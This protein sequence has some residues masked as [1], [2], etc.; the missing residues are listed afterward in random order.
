MTTLKLFEL[1]SG[2][3]YVDTLLRGDTV[4]FSGSKIMSEIRPPKYVTF[5]PS[6]RRDGGGGSLPLLQPLLTLSRC[7]LLDRDF[8]IAHM[9]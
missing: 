7:S 9:A 3:V 4:S 1:F 2:S 6:L 5:S 8:A